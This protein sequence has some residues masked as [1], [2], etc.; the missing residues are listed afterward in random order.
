MAHFIRERFFERRERWQ[1]F[2]T[3]LHQ[4]GERSAANPWAVVFEAVVRFRITW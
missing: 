4:R 3:P 2:A 1:S